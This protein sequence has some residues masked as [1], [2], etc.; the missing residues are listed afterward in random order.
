M[1]FTLNVSTNKF[2]S[3]L[4]LENICNQFAA[5]KIRINNAL[6]YHVAPTIGVLKPGSK[7]NI[8]IVLTNDVIFK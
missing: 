8:E 2:H 5:F 4:Q 6:A 3:Q 7:I 1:V